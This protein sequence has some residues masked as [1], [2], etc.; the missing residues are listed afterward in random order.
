MRL[1]YQ[2]GVRGYDNEPSESSLRI[3]MHQFLRIFEKDPFGEKSIKAIKAECAAKRILEE[4]QADE[5]VRDG[6]YDDAASM[7]AMSMRSRSSFRS[8]LLQSVLGS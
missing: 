3:Q 5:S 4:E 1:A 2:L 8:V 6:N 7:S